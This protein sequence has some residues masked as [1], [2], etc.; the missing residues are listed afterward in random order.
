MVGALATGY[1]RQSTLR[2]AALR[3]IV[4]GLA[5]AGFAWTGSLWVALGAQVLVGYF[6]FSVMTGLQT[7]IQQIVDEGKRGRVMSLFQVAWAGLVPFGGFAMGATTDQ[8]GVVPTLLGT[9]AAC[10]AIGV[11][12]LAG[13]ERW[14]A[15]RI[16]PAAAR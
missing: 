14:S 1:E 9:A 7:L 5:L 4:Y 11:F 3:V 8:V 15:P 10:T 16:S 12:V 13:A 2:G 6:Y